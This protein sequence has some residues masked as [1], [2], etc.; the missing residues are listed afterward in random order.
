MRVG[1]VSDIHGNKYALDTVLEELQPIDLLVCCGDIV[2]Y[3]PHPEYCVRRIRDVADIVV[4]GNHDRYSSNPT[5]YN[6]PAVVGALRHAQKQLSHHQMRWLQSLPYI[7]TDYDYTVFHSHPITPE[8]DVPPEETEEFLQYVDDG[9][10]VMYGHT[11]TPCYRE[12]DT[13]RVL[14]PGSVGQP[15]DGDT[16]ASYGILTS[17]GGYTER[18]EY[19]VEATVQDIHDEGLS[20][21]LAT[22]LRNGT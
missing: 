20:E 6:N 9:T 21:E 10:T 16:R 2:G 19:D 3:G 17:N 22:R 13:G 12:F 11:H 8:T 14:N 7:V 15:R 1:V 18:V 4:Q 5:R